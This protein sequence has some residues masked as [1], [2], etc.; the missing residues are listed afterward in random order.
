MPFV[1]YPTPA[2]VEALIRSAG[3]WPTSSAKQ[4]LALI[5]AQIGAEAAKDE[6][7]HLTGW[8]P[9]LA[10]EAATE[11]EF[12]TVDTRGYIDFEGGALE[13]E[14]VTINGT[15]LV[16][17]TGYRPQPVNA[18][19]RKEAFTGIEV[20]SRFG[21]YSSYAYGS[22]GLNPFIVSARWGRVDEIP[23][24]VWQ[25]IQQRAALIVLTQ[26]DNLQNIASLSQDGFSK[27]YDVVGTITQKDL[28]AGGIGGEGVW[29]KNFAL[30][31]QRWTRVVH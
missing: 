1:A 11:R 5:Q 6:F 17:R 27:A 7:E 2:D 21:G 30:I 19:S 31:A 24:D 16:F 26:I 23:G 20:G 29:G 12:D 10:D 13:I 25:A 18:I 15:P 9:F 3:Y 8:T 4:S 28:A 22:S 14:S